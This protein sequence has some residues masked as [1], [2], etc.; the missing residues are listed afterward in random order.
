MTVPFSGRRTLLDDRPRPINDAAGTV[1]KIVGTIST[2]AAMLVGWGLLS[3]T[4]LDAVEA[5]LG[6]VP[7]LV[8]LIASALSAF[9]V[10][11][12]AEPEVTP[13]SDPRDNT[14]QPLVRAA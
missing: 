6:A 8:G 4:Q 7:G 14:G 13:L 5:L 11:R 1:T 2:L 9:G 10:V 3:A 12:R